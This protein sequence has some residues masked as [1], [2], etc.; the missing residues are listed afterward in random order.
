MYNNKGSYFYSA[1]GLKIASDFYLPELIKGEDLGEIDINI[2]KGEVPIE[3]DK[4]ICEIEYFKASQNELIFEVEGVAKYYM[5]NGNT[6]I[7]QPN[8]NAND[9]SVKLYLLGAALGTILLQR[10]IIPVHGSAVVIQGKAV[11]FTGVSGAGKSTLSS[12][13]RKMGHLFLADDISVVVINKEGIPVVQPGYPQ[14]KLWSDSLE[15]MREDISQLSKVSPIED[16][17]ALPVQEGFLHS[18]VP[19]SAI[20]EIN[21]EECSSVEIKQISGTD[22]LNILLRNIY[23]E[24]FFRILGVKSDYLMQCLKI[25]KNIEFFKLVRP[26]EIFSLEEQIRLIKRKLECLV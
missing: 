8:E 21:P 10:G 13:F 6:I 4:A 24:V 17:Y 11:I 7:V 5:T 2:V 25:S 16:K 23:R 15:I 14:Q 26:K 22:K 9:N 19:L 3:I 18:P 12:A 1:F 20:F